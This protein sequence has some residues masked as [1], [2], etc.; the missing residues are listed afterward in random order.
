LDETGCGQDPRENL[1]IVGVEPSF[2]L[3]DI[4]QLINMDLRETGCEDGRWMELA[5]NRVQW[6]ALVLAVLN[7]RVLLPESQLISEMDLRETG[8]E[9]GRW[10]E[11][12]QNRVQW[13]ALVL[14]VL[15]LRV[16]LPEI[17]WDIRSGIFDSR[18]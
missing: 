2:L 7:L 13:R 16:L 6:R 9:D 5:Q 14:A 11:L 10:I 3:Q 17:Y 12:A 4:H 1:V 18:R 8:C 15:N